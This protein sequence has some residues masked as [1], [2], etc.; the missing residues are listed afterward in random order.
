MQALQ[1]RVAAQPRLLQLKQSQQIFIVWQLSSGCCLVNIILTTLLLLLP[2]ILI[3][4][5]PLS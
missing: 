2:L 3:L 1:K 4:L 5:P